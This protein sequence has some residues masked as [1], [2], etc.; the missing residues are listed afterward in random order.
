M[1]GRF[2]QILICVLCGALLLIAGCTT[3]APSGEAATTPTVRATQAP[4]AGADLGT[5]AGLLQTI[6]DQLTVIGENTQ[7]TLKGIVTGNIIL[8]DTSGNTASTIT[9][10]SA[11]I[12][13]PRGTCDI[14]VYGNQQRM[15]ITLEEMKDYGSVK[16]SRDYQACADVYICRKT[17]TLDDDFAFLFVTYKP[18]DDKYRLSL[19]TL[20][21]RCRS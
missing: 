2:A 11:V 12:A 8:F 17:V 9:N 21:Y 16:Y 3:P 19:V 4:V 13:L 10:G 1:N 15:Y 7:P 5:V 20:G 6:S 18:Y 14:A